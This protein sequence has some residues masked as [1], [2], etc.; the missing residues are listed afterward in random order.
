M[1]EIIFFLTLRSPDRVSYQCIS[2]CSNKRLPFSLV[3]AVYLIV[4]R[5]RIHGT[6]RTARKG[7]CFFRELS[8]RN[9]LKGTVA[10]MNEGAVNAIVKIDIG[11]GNV[12][13]AAIS[14]A[15]VMV[16]IDD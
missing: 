14:M 5:R 4:F 15:S 11:G 2:F 6:P 1:G 12:I 8:A 16:G 13:S 7:S 9:P 3:F 10:E